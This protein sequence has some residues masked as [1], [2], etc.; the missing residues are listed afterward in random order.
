MK[1]SR[2]E[3]EQEQI[4]CALSDLQ[5]VEIRLVEQ[6][7]EQALW[8]QLV[9]RH[10]YLGFQGNRGRKLRYLLSAGNHIIG[11]I[12]WKSGSL[13]LESRDCFIG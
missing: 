1:R 2:A 5:P 9:K 12:G 8:E 10:H 11:A 6:E 4:E 13:N 7:A 3:L